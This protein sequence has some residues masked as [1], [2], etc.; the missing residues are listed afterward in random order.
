MG[1]TFKIKRATLVLKKLC[2]GLLTEDV[3]G[4]ND[5]FIEAIMSNSDISILCLYLCEKHKQTSVRCRKSTGL[6]KINHSL[7]EKLAQLSK[8]MDKASKINIKPQQGL[9]NM[10]VSLK[11]KQ[12]LLTGII[13]SYQ[14]IINKIKVSGVIAKLKKRCQQVTSESASKKSLKEAMTASDV[15]IKCLNSKI[16]WEESFRKYDNGDVKNIK[17][18]NSSRV[19]TFLSC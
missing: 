3:L 2:P 14:A 6:Y 10:M 16:A 12:A 15:T 7:Q 8:L 5:S 17:N 18:F 1:E 13:D 11:S 9:S 19:R 4:S